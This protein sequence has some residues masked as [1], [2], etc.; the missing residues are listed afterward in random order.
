[1]NTRVL[2]LFVIVLFIIV[3]FF[4]F[5]GLAL[6]QGPV[7]T[8]LPTPTPSLMASD[9]L[10]SLGPTPQDARPDLIVEKIETNPAI[11]KVG[12]ST[13]ISVTIRNQGAG[14]VSEGNNYLTDLYIDPPFDPIINYHQ[15]VSP[16][17]GLPWGAQWFYVPPGGSYVFTTTWVFTD[18]KTF[19]VWAQ[20]DSDNNVVEENEDNNT[21]QSNFSVLTAQSF[22]HDTHQ[23][24][25]TNMAST[26]DNSDPS[27]ALRLG[28]FSE[29]PHIEWPF[30]DGCEITS[31]T[32]TIADYNMQMPDFRINE[33]MTGEQVKPHLFANGEGIVIAVWQ[34]GRNGDTY[35][36]D[37]YLRYSTDEGQTWGQEE[38]VND[39]PAGNHI[40]QLNPVAA[41]SKKGDLL[42]AWQDRRNGDY[43]IYAQ[44]L[45]IS[46]TTLIRSGA[47]MLV[48]GAAS[49]NTGDQINP[50]IAVDETGGFHVTWQDNRNGND[51]I[52]ASSYIPDNGGYTWTLVRQVNDDNGAPQQ[53]PTIQALD[54]L[55]PTE[56]T[57]TVA[58]TPPYTVTVTGIISEPAKI[59]V[60]TWEDYR[61]GYADVSM[62]VSADGGETFGFD[63]FITNSLSD[64]HQQNPDVTLTKGT[65]KISF[66]VPLPGNAQT[67]VEVEVPVSV[68]HSVWE[69]HR[70]PGSDGDIFYN[71][72][73]LAVEQI[74]EGNDL[75]FVLDLGASNE[76][77]NQNDARAWQ[78]KPPDQREPRLVAIP[79]GEDADE[80]KWNLF[81]A[82]ADGRNYDS[83]N[84][85]IYYV[86]KSTCEGMPP[87]LATNQML[88]DG[89]RLHQFDATS[90]SYDDYDAGSPPPGY[91]I[92]PSVA[93]DIQTDW[94]YVLGGYLYLAW[95]DDRAGDHQSEN[96]IYFARSNL[97]FFNQAPHGY[98]YGAGSQISDILDSESDDTTWYTLDWSAATDASTYVTI[99]TR[100]GDT[101]TDVLTSA[102]YPQRFPFQPQ[103]WDCNANQSGAPL[104]GYDAP[105]QHIEDASG[106]F[107]PQARYIQY[108]VNF[109][110]RDSTKTPELDDL[111]IYFDHEIR[112]DN[113]NGNGDPGTNSQVILPIV[114]K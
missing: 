23:D 67:E 54:W 38:R 92:K 97:T 48:G 40:N 10:S 51:D 88:N 114:L 8:T 39:D 98:G 91:Q 28:H 100:L 7:L 104:P 60:V 13:T 109:F 112:E 101:I 108:R 111:I 15:I 12:Q 94:P 46:G 11:P 103:P 81:I 30:S 42:V 41:L 85:D 66:T 93:T 82:W 71:A 86:V 50:D 44:R 55:E 105:G 84:Y 83:W 110:T 24:F 99:Q 73:Q 33:V 9:T 1:M 58:P 79:C 37:I 2:S 87:G 21:Q 27:G 59:L 64:G 36:R 75:R 63:G 25:L 77:I 95:Q 90:P 5:F 62:A 4:A 34:D 96:D 89:V 53:N 20:V 22:K 102:W 56:V 106:D 17:L 57:Y 29:P 47:N 68:I 69:G 31:S 65:N 32:V 3:F 35:N 6:G 52:F 18:V 26:L 78:T 61:Q 16:T 45:V 14:I 49:Y 80:E 43:D 76:Q 107:W 19:D 70:S 72:S 74:G 113:G